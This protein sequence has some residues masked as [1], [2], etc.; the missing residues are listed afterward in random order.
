MVEGVA[1]KSQSPL[2]ATSSPVLMFLALPLRLAPG[3]PGA[4]AGRSRAG[5][6]AGSVQLHA[7]RVGA[8]RRGDL[9]H[10]RGG[11]AAGRR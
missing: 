3:S 5:W 2:E 7:Q 1:W 6:G 9:V 4:P 10:Q 8:G 11:S